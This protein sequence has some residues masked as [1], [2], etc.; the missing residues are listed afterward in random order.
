MQRHDP[1]WMELQREPAWVRWLFDVGNDEIPRDRFVTFA[2]AQQL[3]RWF[4]KK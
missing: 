1:T 4:N 2:A 3:R